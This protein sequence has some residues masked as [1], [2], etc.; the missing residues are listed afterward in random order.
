MKRYIQAYILILISLNP[1]ISQDNKNH[2][3]APYINDREKELFYQMYVEHS[4]EI[5]DNW[6]SERKIQNEN[7]YNYNLPFI[8]KDFRVNDDFGDAYQFFAD[9]AVGDSGN[10]II[11]W[12]DERQ[13]DRYV[14][15]Q[16]FDKN[17][18]AL[19]QN[20]NVD[21]MG[22]TTKWTPPTV[23]FYK[24]GKFLVSW[25]DYR[26]AN[27]DVYARRFNHNGKPLQKAFRVNDDFDRT[28]QGSPSVAIDSSG[29][30]FIVWR[31]WRDDVGN[32]ERNI[33][34]QLYDP[35]GN[36]IN[37]NFL[38]NPQQNNIDHG[39]P[40]VATNKAGHFVV[41]WEDKRNG[42]WDIYAKLYNHRGEVILENF[43]VNDDSGTRNQWYPEV[44]VDESGNFIIVWQDYRNGNW[45][46]YAQRFDS[47]GIPLG[48]NFRVND[49]LGS[50]DQWYPTVAVDDLGNFVIVWEDKRND[51]GDIYGQRYNHEGVPLG[52]NFI[53]NTEKSNRQGAPRVKLWNG[54]IYTVWESIHDPTAGYDIWANVLDWNDPYTR[55][56]ENGS[57]GVST[58]HL[59]QNYPNPFNPTTTIQYTLPKAG[60]V[61]LK[62]YNS[63][64]QVVR[65]LVEEHQPA[66][67]YTVQWNGRDDFGRQMPAG[68]YFY[69]LKAGQFEQVRKMVLVR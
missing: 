63:L 3:L 61:I 31:D 22:V 55:I 26:N 28:I 56:A 59:A 47:N 49:D 65:T 60:K 1:I 8:K 41:V 69:R 11:V 51:S 17:G 37:G 34:A 58:Y 50:S 5:P 7:L 25:Q 57:A 52:N 42:N 9:I 48:Q 23:M 6:Q 36:A 62:I 21:S 27:W 38:V 43:R 13:E 19:S 66:G 10:F 30:T 14:Y 4:E 44:A 40:A 45:D 33:Y 32:D 68:I 29:N 12:V 46:I 16:R 64:G 39:A 35:N 67:R 20:F 24:T 2:H 54:K 18:V 53:I 15:A